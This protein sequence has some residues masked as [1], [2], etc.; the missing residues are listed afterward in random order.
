M[1]QSLTLTD[2]VTLNGFK[3]AIFDLD[4]TLVDNMGV[5]LDIWIE[6]LRE[7][8]VEMTP[9]AFH[10]KYAGRT[11]PAILQGVFGD[12]FGA[13]EIQRIGD[14]KEAL[15]R[16]RY[17]PHLRPV[18]GLDEL[19]A[20]MTDSD[21]LCGVASSGSPTNVYFVLD[22][23]GWRGR[24]KAVVT[25]EDVRHCKPHPEA[26]LTA[27]ERM[28]IAPEDC[29][30]FEDAPVGIEAARRAGMACVALTTTMPSETLAG[31]PGVLAAVPD[32]RAVRVELR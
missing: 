10:E 31:L 16:E 3:A 28:G 4:G 27:A 32:Y 30:V 18:P 17:A 25:G 23:L 5:H 26:F 15:Y 22:R 1:P 21:W 20:D 8:G 13:E 29:V 7:L 6:L 11:N 2:P 24:F 12:R 14:H 9:H 19:I